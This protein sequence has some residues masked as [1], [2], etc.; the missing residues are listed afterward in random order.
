MPNQLVQPGE[1]QMGLLVHAAFGAAADLGLG[2][3]K[4]FVDARHFR[5]VEDPDR[6][7]VAA[8]A[9]G[10]DLGAAQ[11]PGQC[12]LP[13]TSMKVCFIFEKNREANRSQ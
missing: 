7:M 5:G 8:L 2:R 9:V 13:C 12:V 3:A 11:G 10:R 4:A 6:E 1:E